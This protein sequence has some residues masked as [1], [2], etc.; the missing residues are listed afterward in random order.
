[1]R[2][3][4][5]LAKLLMRLVELRGGEPKI[6]LPSIFNGI[7]GAETSLCTSVVDQLLLSMIATVSNSGEYALAARELGT[8]F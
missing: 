1:M 5:E 8:S 2:P 3:A 4:I 7:S 6:K